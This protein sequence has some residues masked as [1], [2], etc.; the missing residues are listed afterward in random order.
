MSTKSITVVA[1]FRARPRKA[2]ELKAVLVGLLAPA[3]KGAGCLNYDLH[4]SPKERAK[5]L[6]HEN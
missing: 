2:A 4:Q 1:T 5:C 6:F 3:R